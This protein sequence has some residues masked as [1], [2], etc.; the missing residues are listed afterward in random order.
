MASASDA[1]SLVE[2]RLLDGP[3][4]YFPRPAAKVTLDLSELLGLEVAVARDLGVE[5]GLG[6]TRPGAAG[7]VFRQRFAIRLVTQIV[8][9]LATAGGATR[10]AVR[11]RTGQ[12]V[13]EL[14]VAYP[15]RN[16]GR[17]EG[18]AYGL[19]RVLDRVTA[20]PRAVAEMIV[21]EGAALAAAPL[22]SAPQLIRPQI[23]VVAI[24]GTNGKTT[25]ARMIGHIAR[26]AGRLVGWSSTDGVYIDGRLVE[27]GD[28]SGP[29]GAGRV[30]RHP[31]VELAVTETARGGILRRGVGVAYNDVSVV[32]NISADHL[33][34]GG[35]DTLD[36]LAEVKAVITKIT[37]PGGWCVLNADD[38]RTLAMRL[39]TKAR[40]WVFTRDPDSP[41][42]RT[43]LS[44]GGR[45]TTLLGGWVC[46]L[47]PGADPL[48]VVEVIDVPM[49]LAGLS[50]VNV[51]NVLAVTSATLALGFSVEQVA[52]GLR[53]FDPNENNP[54]RMNIWTLPVPSGAISVV[55]DL[56]HNEAGLEALLEIMS[57]IRPPHGRLLLG[58]GTAGD[59]G[60]EVFVRLGEIAAV[61]A[62][63]VEIV[64]K[65]DYLRGRSMAE[66][67]E[68]I[69]EGA[70]HAGM[71]IQRAHDSELA[72]LVSLVDQARDG[73]VVAI[74]THQ[75]REELDRW[76]LDHQ[77]T[78]D[79]A[80]ALRAK[81]LRAGAT[82]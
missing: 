63:V 71:A 35:I 34:L 55:I 16:A 23:P 77:A 79:D 20:G 49:T 78:R 14:V 13:T 80:V 81:I 27:A 1:R 59:R 36:Q 69:T 70:A 25:T 61:G 50:R 58:V 2:L 12:A 47:A 45:M 76:L 32:T 10:L 62:D 48:Q 56:A 67:S 19:A 68:L 46:V 5:L 24:T 75:D 33:G 7:S 42:G 52:D 82:P 66:I 57:G 44:G 3:N 54:G 37:K 53:S 72:G 11:T 15:W 39:G 26:Q 21:V 29:S 8:R 43:V 51:E 18:L 28:F 30:L 17:A 74:M 40:I 4:L 64:H 73:D 9:R 41:G 38:P 6:N 60:N 31:G 65:G 22:G